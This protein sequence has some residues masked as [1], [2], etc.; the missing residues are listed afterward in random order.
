MSGTSAPRQ[1]DI[2]TA[3]RERYADAA[4]RVLGTVDGSEADA[5]CDPGAS[6]EPEVG[7]AERE[8][9][10]KRQRTD[11]RA[12]D[13]FHLGIAHFF[14]FTAADNLEAQR[15]LNEARSVDPDFADAHA[16]WSYAVVLGM[17]YW[18]TDPEPELLEAA[19]QATHDAL[20]RDHHNAVFHM[21]R[22]RVHLAR[23]DYRAALVENQ[24]AVV[25]KPPPPSAAL[26]LR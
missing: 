26:S 18:D 16:W 20:A 3:V 8:R 24:M 2:H 14:R 4:R 11:L 5:C 23:R 7:Y 15:L 9:V 25:V 13:L 21:L 19:L 1:E 12:W 22:G 17:T 6:L 10:A